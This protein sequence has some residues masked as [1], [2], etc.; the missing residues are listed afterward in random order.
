MK[1]KKELLVRSCVWVG[2]FEG[3][4]AVLVW[5][6]DDFKDWGAKALV[7]L[8]AALMNLP[9][10]VLAKALN[11]FDNDSHQ[12]AGWILTLVVGALFWMAVMWT[13]RM[14]RHNT[15]NRRSS[16]LIASHE[17]PRD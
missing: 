15:S 5:T 9:G 11:L 2:L 13:A 17:N 1:T 7:I 3:L 12:V 14:A 16:R 4:L 10:V 6:V 8:F